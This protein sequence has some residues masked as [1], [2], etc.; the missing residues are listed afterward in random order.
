[1]RDE[2]VRWELQLHN[3]IRVFKVNLNVTMKLSINPGLYEE[4]LLKVLRMVVNNHFNKCTFV[5]LRLKVQKLKHL[6]VFIIFKNIEYLSVYDHYHLKHLKA[7][8]RFV[9]EGPPPRYIPLSELYVSL[10]LQCTWLKQYLFVSKYIYNNNLH[11]YKFQIGPKAVSLQKTN[12]LI[13]T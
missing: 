7:K 5:V 4:G 1:M 6:H 9:A 13:N 2:H 12:H 10:V 8:N 11:I 3:I